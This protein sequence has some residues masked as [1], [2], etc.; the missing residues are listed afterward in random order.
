MIYD[1]IIPHG[2]ELSWVRVVMGTSCRGY[3]L[4]W[5]WVVL[6]T[7]CLRYELSWVRFV[8]G[9]SCLGYELS[10]VR[11]VQ[12]PCHLNKPLWYQYTKTKK[13][14]KKNCMHNS[15]NVLLS[16]LCRHV[17]RSQSGSCWNETQSDEGD[18][19]PLITPA[20]YN[21]LIYRYP[22]DKIHGT[23]FIIKMAS[24]QYRNSHCGDK[25][26]LRRLISIMRL[27][28]LVRYHRHI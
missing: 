13:K 3:E 2:Y 7:S 19:Y 11:V 15:W 14:T 21:Q 25:T 18:K 26:I 22:D 4:S 12:I 10:W 9:T 23:W 8:L 20:T 5:V 1:D 16:Y 6:G 28:V 27:P 17:S 24:Y